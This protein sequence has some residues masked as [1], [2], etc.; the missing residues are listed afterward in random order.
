[1]AEPQTPH[2]AQ[3]RARTLVVTSGADGIGKTQV[4]ANLAVALA[5]RGARVTL[6]DGDLAQG[7]LDLVLG[8]TPRWDLGQVLAGERTLD[9]VAIAGPQG[10]KLIAAPAHAP[11]L[12]EIDDV[13]R[14]RLVRAIAALDATDFVIVDTVAGAGRTT[15][16]LCRLAHDL[17]VV[18]TP[19]TMSAPEAY[20]LVR[21]LHAEGALA[22]SP[23][24]V[25]NLA[26]SDDEA[27]D[28]VARLQ[29]F[30]R[31]FLRLEFERL[32]V[33]PS[34]PSVPMA[35]RQQEPVVVSAP[36]SPAA[37]AFRELAAR[38]WKPVPAGPDVDALPSSPVRLRA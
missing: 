28:T 17:L 20:G 37:A 33:V 14:E 18:A 3:P 35:T 26:G 27:E 5:E 22:R 23:R 2:R 8:V 12:A 32:G 30:A 24:L 36:Q 16:D 25:V 13:R 10:V 9:E 21:T 1:M 7:Q 29:M 19:E 4:A 38:L 6:V 31:H 11:E 34:D 15:L